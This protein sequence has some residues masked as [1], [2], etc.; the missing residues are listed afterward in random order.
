MVKSKTMVSEKAAI[1]LLSRLFIDPAYDEITL[2]QAYNAAGRGDQNPVQNR[3]WLNT[4]IV[5]LRQHS[6]IS[7]VDKY[8]NSRTKLDKLRITAV[9]RNALGWPSNNFMPA[10]VGYVN[11]PTKYPAMSSTDLAKAVAVFRND[12]PDFDVIFEVKLKEQPMQKV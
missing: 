6:L 9:G 12:N 8:E 3:N 4:V 7:T 11:V 10:N 2:A 5:K 1:Q